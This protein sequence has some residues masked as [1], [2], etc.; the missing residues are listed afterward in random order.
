MKT[1]TNLDFERE[2]DVLDIAKR[3]VDDID[4][5][6]EEESLKTFLEVEDRNVREFEARMR[7]VKFIERKKREQNARDDA[8]FLYV[9]LVHLCGVDPLTARAFC[10]PSPLPCIS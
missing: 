10:S 9:I 6:I 3:I 8:R 7:A 4:S 1:N 2:A 5:K